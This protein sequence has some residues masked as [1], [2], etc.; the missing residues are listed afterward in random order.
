M[1]LNA[2]AVGVSATP[3]MWQPMSCLEGQLDATL[4]GAACARFHWFEGTF[5]R[6]KVLENGVSTLLDTLAPVDG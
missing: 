3:R 6:E 2:W 5:N 1:I 4:S